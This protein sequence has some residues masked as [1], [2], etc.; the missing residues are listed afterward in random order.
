MSTSVS[1]N[2]GANARV[3]RR[4]YRVCRRC[5]ARSLIVIGVPPSC[6]TRPDL[7][8]AAAGTSFPAVLAEPLLP[9]KPPDAPGGA[10]GC[11]CRRRGATFRQ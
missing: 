11:P 9:A 3:S 2:T 8:A 5:G 6:R 4:K 1:R 10:G 7:V